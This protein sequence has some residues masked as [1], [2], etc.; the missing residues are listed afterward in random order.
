MERAKKD[1][2]PFFMWW[3][4]TRMHIFTHLKAESDGKTGLGI[5]ADG[6][7]STTATSARC[8]PS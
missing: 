8:S 6:M 4:S 5:Y 7:T 3:N 2:K 1:D